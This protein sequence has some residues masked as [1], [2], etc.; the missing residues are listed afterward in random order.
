MKILDRFIGIELFWPFLFGVAAFT[1][2]MFATQQLLK[3]T[4]L[5]LQGVPALTA[6]KLLVLALPGVIIY[7]LP[8]SA[9]LAVLVA[10]S[11]LSND[12]EVTALY[13]SGISLYRSVVPVVV[14]GVLVSALGFMMSELIVPQ[15]NRLS[16][17]IKSRVIKEG[18]STDRPF[19]IVDR[20]TNT[21]IY[22]RGG[23][24]AKTKTMRDV[25]ITRYNESGPSQLFQARTARWEG[26]N[27]WSLRDGKW[28][29]LT[30]SD[31]DRREMSSGS[32]KGLES[33]PVE[34]S[35]TPQDIIRNQLG[36]EEMTFRELRRQISSLGGGGIQ[37]KDLIELEV[38]LYNKLAIPVAALVF[39]LIG[40]PLAIRP[41]RTGT[42]VGIGLSI[43]IIFAYWFTWHFTSALALQGS[44]SPAIGAFTADILGILLGIILLLRSAK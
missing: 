1:S 28:Y 24:S 10:F 11:R 32:F 19:M 27:T 6:F 36:P 9:L 37:P 14:L 43:L 8:M 25:T 40:A 41:A 12:S 26:G 17:A 18:V 16:N 39:A 7:T 21:T 20:D 22:I 33:E 13:A 35:Q 15:S 34:L 3:L 44:L 42:S 5:V 4:N 2:I 23:F 38:D 30:D 29:I 31:R